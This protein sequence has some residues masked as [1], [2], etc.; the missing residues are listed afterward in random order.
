M[1]TRTLR[2]IAF[3]A[4]VPAL[5]SCG[6][7]G[8]VSKVGEAIE[9]EK[10]VEVLAKYKGL[11]NKTVA[12]VMNAERSVLY[13]FPTVVPN[14]A[15]NVAAGIKQYVSG[16]QVLDFR[17][18]L[19]WCYRTPSWTTL[20]LGHIAEELGVDRV[21]YVDIIEFRLNPPG[22]RWIWEGM[23]G[24]NVGII[25]RDSLDPD[26][27]AEEFS[28]S[29]KFPDVKDLSRE[30]ASEAQVQLGLVAKF[31]QTVNKLFYDH[32]E[33]KYPNKKLKGSG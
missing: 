27:F 8:L 10:K 5:A 7:F 29:V 23:A 28:I 24:A 21:V 19:A 11:E 16:S 9:V 13:E 4:L 3:L 2:M 32:L 14:V 30:S 26:A 17:E 18:S 15:A 22:N 1:N 31:T 25:E 33:D 12:V 20:P 6:M